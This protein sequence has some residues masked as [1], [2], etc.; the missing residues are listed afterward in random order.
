MHDLGKVVLAANFDEQYSG[1]QSLARKQQLVMWEVEKEIFGASHAEIGA[2]LLGLWGMPLD[3]LEAAAL[4]H[5]PSSTITKGFTPLTAVHV[6]NVLV[7]ELN[8]DKEGT[9]PSKLDEAYLTDIG[10]FDRLEVW[11]ENVAGLEGTKPET[12]AKP[13]ESTAPKAA[14]PA[15]KPVRSAAHKPATS[16]PTQPVAPAVAARPSASGWSFQDKPWLYAGAGAAVIAMVAWFGFTLSSGPSGNPPAPSRAVASSPAARPATAVAGAP[17]KPAPDGTTPR[18]P[19]TTP[20]PFA[21]LVAR[22]RT[23]PVATTNSGAIA[24]APKAPASNELKLQG[25]FFSSGQPSAIING[26][27]L[28]VND[29]YAGNKVVSIGRSN[30]VVENNGLRK[31]LTLK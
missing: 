12:K 11:R 6:A 20:G 30:V 4:H 23:E 25:I 31:T 7:H 24:A 13:A 16:L 10:M 29:R 9:V 14:K 27:Y 3:L 19:A 8:P 1:A 28:H 18:I 22:A 21:P 5:Q 2:Y 17:S 26:Q 15:P